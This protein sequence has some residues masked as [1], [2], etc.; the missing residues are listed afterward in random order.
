MVGGK[1]I[2]LRFGLD[3]VTGANGAARVKELRAVLASTP[4]VAKTA[5]TGKALETLDVTGARIWLRPKTV[6]AAAKALGITARC[7]SHREHIVEV[8]RLPDT[9]ST[10]GNFMR[11]EREAAIE[12]AL[13][14]L[15]ARSIRF[16]IRQDADPAPNAPGLVQAAG[17]VL[18]AKK[19]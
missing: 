5:L 2:T 17:Y 1:P 19:K 18:R 7:L 4:G 10:M 15:A 6:A 13:P 3:G 8:Q 14:G 16:L 12:L 11:M 9:P